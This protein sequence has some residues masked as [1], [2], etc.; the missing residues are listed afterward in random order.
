MLRWGVCFAAKVKGKHLKQLL[1]LRTSYYTNFRVETWALEGS[2]FT[3]MAEVQ[4][5]T[6]AA[7]SNRCGTLNFATKG[8]KSASNIKCCVI[9]HVK[10]N[11]P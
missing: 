7:C 9:G 8:I 6:S 4:H 5:F 3:T 2:A 10:V 11:N 1:L